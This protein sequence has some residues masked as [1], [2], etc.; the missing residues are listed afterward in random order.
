MPVWWFAIC[1]IRFRVYIVMVT[2]M[3]L[4]TSMPSTT[5]TSTIAA[6][7]TT[8]VTISCW[9]IFIY[10]F[11]RWLCWW[12]WTFYNSY[13]LFI[14]GQTVVRIFSGSFCRHVCWIW[15]IRLRRIGHIDCVNRWL[16]LTFTSRLTHTHTHPR[17][18]TNAKQEEEEETIL[19]I[20]HFPLLQFIRNS[21]DFLAIY[22]P[23][24]DPASL[25]YMSVKLLLLLRTFRIQFRICSCG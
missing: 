18:S 24:D 7:A 15:E 12:F 9:H 17:I 2:M 21:N 5:T 11:D 3:S 14:A 4:P 1:C 6:T 25:G 13:C 22:I 19:I 23:Q 8:I 20:E 16:C 10:N